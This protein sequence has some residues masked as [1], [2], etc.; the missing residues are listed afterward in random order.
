MEREYVRYA[1][2]WSPQ[3]RS[4]LA[5]FGAAW[6]GWCAESGTFSERVE[7]SCLPADRKKYLGEVARTGLHALIHPPFGLSAD[8]SVWWLDDS[9]Q[10]LARSLPVTA[11]PRFNVVVS[12]DRVVLAPE[13]LSGMIMMLMDRVAALVGL[14]EEAPTGDGSG[15]RL[16]SIDAPSRSAPVGR[17]EIPLTGVVAPDVARKL[18]EHLS[19]RLS[20][21][22]EAEQMATDLSLLGDPGQGRPWRLLE[23][24][25]LTT[26][27]IRTATAEPTGMTCP[28]LHPMPPLNSVL[29]STWDTVIA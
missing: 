5:K 9:M 24:Y 20:D 3:S 18:V 22:F 29:G 23:R 28:G 10:E 12:G 8:H 26:D 25:P 7:R 17:F 14:T 19:V 1:I 21:V 4:C 11:L 15:A 6:S 13:H 16:P 27:P 2:A